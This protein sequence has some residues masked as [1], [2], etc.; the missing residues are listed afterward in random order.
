MTKRGMIKR[1][2][3]FDFPGYKPDTR[4]SGFAYPIRASVHLYGPCYI[5]LELADTAFDHTILIQE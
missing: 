4:L 3:S 5:H 2:F 1:I